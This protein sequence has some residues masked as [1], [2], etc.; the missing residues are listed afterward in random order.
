MVSN[1]KRFLR[2]LFVFTD[3]SVTGFSFT[4]ASAAQTLTHD[5]RTTIN[6]NIIVTN[7]A[8]AAPRN[9]I[10]SVSGNG[11]E[12]FAFEMRISDVD[13]ET[14]T[15]TLGLYP[16]PAAITT[17]LK[18]GLTTGSSVTF[19]GSADVTLPSAFCVLARYMCVRLMNGTDASYTDANVGS[20]SN[21]RCATIY[22]RTICE[23]GRPTVAQTVCYRKNFN[24]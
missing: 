2:R 23:T 13:M 5:E 11:K 24:E 9:N 16:S 6:I 20:T 18:R 22:S 21:V 14:D 1:I 8:S 10:V 17:D 19:V 15:D 3:P 12:N 7:V 4:V